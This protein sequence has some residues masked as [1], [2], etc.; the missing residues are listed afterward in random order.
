VGQGEVILFSMTMLVLAIE[1]LGWHWVDV[2]M[3]RKQSPGFV[4]PPFLVIKFFF[5]LLLFFVW[6]GNH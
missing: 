4:G 3:G 2:R 5:F 6:T 1:R